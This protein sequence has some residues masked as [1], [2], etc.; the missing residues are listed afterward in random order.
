MHTKVGKGE[1]IAVEGCGLSSSLSSPTSSVARSL[2]FYCPLTACHSELSEEPGCFVLISTCTTRE[3]VLLISSSLLFFLI[4]KVTK[5]SRLR[6]NWLKIT[7]KP[8]PGELATCSLVNSA[9]IKARTAPALTAYCA[10]FLTPFFRGRS[11]SVSHV[12]S[13]QLPKLKA[14]STISLQLAAH[15]SQLSFQFPCKLGMTASRRGM[16]IAAINACL[17]ACVL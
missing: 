8:K 1:G 15:S 9:S 4:K 7:G 3:A 13:C 14:L 2:V 10:I 5:K 17:Q 16:K 11:S 6:K 12:G